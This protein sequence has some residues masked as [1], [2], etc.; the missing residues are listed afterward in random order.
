MNCAEWITLF[1]LFWNTPNQLKEIQIE[2]QQSIEC[3]KQKQCIS[4]WD[5]STQEWAIYRINNL[6]ENCGESPQ[7][8]KAVSDPNGVCKAFYDR[9][10]KKKSNQ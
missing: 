6:K 10:N 5:N 1:H 4:V 7:E 8:N 3:L 2:R 9:L